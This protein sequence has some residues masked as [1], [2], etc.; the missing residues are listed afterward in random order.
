MLKVPNNLANIGL[1]RLICIENEQNKYF[2][3]SMKKTNFQK[4]VLNNLPQ[5]RIDFKGDK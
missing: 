3:L 1:A 5:N 2:D 4:L